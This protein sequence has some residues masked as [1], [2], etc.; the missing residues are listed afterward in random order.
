MRRRS[1]QCLVLVAA[2]TE[3]IG[4]VA[5]GLDSFRLDPGEFYFRLNGKP[6]FLLGRNPAGWRAEQFEPLFQW[7]AESGEKI[8]RIHLT[9]RTARGSRPGEV[10]EQWTRK[11]ERVLDMAAARGLHVLPVMDAWAAW[12]DGTGRH[13]WH[14]WD[15]NPY[16]AA[17]GGPAKGPG[18][19]FRDRE[20]RRL[21]LQWLG[22]LVARWQGRPNILGWEVFSELDL[23]TGASEAAGV[24]FVEQAA[25][26][27]RAADARGRAVTASLSG[28]RQWPKL[29]ASD[30]L[31]IVQ[32]HPY[33]NHAKYRGNLDEMVLSS[34]R[35]R[36]K[37]YGKPV[38][39]GECGLDSRPIPN[40]IVG[41]ARAHTGINHAIWAAAVSGAMNGRML[42]W[43]DGYDQFSKLD[44]RTR[45]RHAAKPIA[46]FVAG[47]DFTGF[48]P[49]S[50][51]DAP[52]LMGAAVGNEQTVLAWFRDD[53]C[54]APNWPTRAI[55]G[56][57]LT[58]V[59]PGAR[60]SWRI[61]FCDTTTG[62]AVESRRLKCATA[63]VL[64]PLPHFEGSIALK[65][66]A[67]EEAE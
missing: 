33:A 8:M 45:Y 35:A 61:Q 1:W 31:D 58:F 32:V 56:R 39:I 16:N 64:V 14:Y 12:N 19:L 51:R 41:S 6:A 47:V 17:L 55:I 7:A 38:L 27:I 43:E 52:G 28:I 23:V 36:L 66:I 10:H 3:G 42:W 50:V 44:Y 5:L 57:S 4:S 9:P 20:C 40:E 60:P 18:E 48:R 26:V 22:R 37:R 29:F 13:H 11:W 25:A 46:S 53:A 67:E 15:R 59:M 21:W 24:E 65:L 30:A 2:A 34:V 63:A 54:V 62:N 49:V